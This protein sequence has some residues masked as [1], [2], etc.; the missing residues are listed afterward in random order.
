MECPKVSNDSFDSAQD[1]GPTLPT[2]LSGTKET[3]KFTLEMAE[4]KSMPVLPPATKRK[5]IAN[6]QSQVSTERAI[7]NEQT[8][9]Q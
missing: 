8:P 1:L 5:L 4:H 6:D 9:T 3:P 2:K 7:E